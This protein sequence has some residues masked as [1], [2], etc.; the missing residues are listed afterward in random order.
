[1]QMRTKTEFDSVI[2]RCDCE[3]KVLTLHNLYM[4]DA[5]GRL[6]TPALIR[7]L[8]QQVISRKEFVKLAAFSVV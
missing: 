3:G 1:L 5:R 6:Y 4:A 8:Y 7:Y 2:L